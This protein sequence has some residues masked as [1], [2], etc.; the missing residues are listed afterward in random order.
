[1]ASICYFPVVEDKEQLQDI[2]SRA[3]W[4]LTFPPIEKITLFVSEAYLTEVSWEVAP[5]MDPAISTSFDVLRDRLEL[6]VACSEA[7]LEP[8]MSKADIILRWKK[9]VK[10]A[11][12]SDKALKRWLQGKKVFQVD[13]E[14]VR[15]EGSFYIE[16][17][18]Y[19]LPRKGELI[20]ENQKRFREMESALGGFSRAYLLATG[21]SVTQYDKFDFE[22]SLTIACN[23]TILDEQLMK[24]AQPKMLVFADPIFHFGPSEY[25][26]SFRRT[27]RKSS[28]QHD[29]YICIPF[30]YYGLFVHHMP[31]LRHRVIAIPFEKGRDYNFD[32]SSEFKVKTTANILTLLMVPLGTSFASQIC[33]LG[34]DGRPLKEDGYFWSHN[35]AVQFNDKLANIREIHPGFFNIDYNDYYI[36][37]CGTLREQIEAG[38]AIGIEFLSIGFSYIPVLSERL[39]RGARRNRTNLDMAMNKT[40]IVDPDGL[41][42]SGHHI[43]FNDHLAN[44]FEEQGAEVSVLCNKRIEKGILDSRPYYLPT[45]SVHTWEFARLSPEQ[46]RV[47]KFVE[48]VQCGLRDAYSPEHNNI[49]YMYTG[50]VQHVDALAKVTRPYQNVFVHVNLFWNFNFDLSNDRWVKTWKGLFEWLDVSAPHVVVTAPTRQAQ[51]E[52]AEL[53]GVILEVAPHP[54]TLVLEPTG[55][56]VRKVGGRESKTTVLFPG[57]AR[58]EK[59]FPDSIEAVRQLGKFKELRTRLRYNVVQ[60]TPE[61][62]RGGVGQLPD[63]ASLVTGEL[64]DEGLID[65]IKESDVVVLPYSPS[66][67]SK[68]TS[69][70]LIDALMLGVPVVVQEGTWLADLVNRYR[71]G[72]VV[73][74]TDAET[75]VNGILEVRRNLEWYKD[76][77]RE[78]AVLYADRNNW[79]YF[80][81]FIGLAT[82]RAS[83]YAEVLVGPYAREVH[84]HWDETKG[85]AQLFKHTFKGNTM[86]DVGAHHGSALMPF[87]E[88][89]WQILAFEPD[90]KNRAKLLGRLGNH[91]NRENVTVDL[92]AV[93]REARSSVSFYRSEESTGISALSAFR[94][95]HR[96]EQKVDIVRLSEALSANGIDDVDFLKVDTEG[97]DLFVLQGFPWNRCTPQVIECEFEDNKTVPL[98]YKFDDL[99]RYLVDKGYYVYVSEWHPIIRYGTKHDWHRLVRYPCALKSEEAWGNLLAFREPIDEAALKRVVRKEL[100]VKGRHED[101]KAP[102]PRAKIPSG[103]GV[104]DSKGASVAMLVG[105]PR[106]DL[107][108]RYDRAF[109]PLGIRNWRYTCLGR[110]YGIWQ[111]AWPNIPLQPGAEYCGFIKLWASCDANV[112]MSL[113]NHTEPDD[114]GKHKTL[115]LKAGHSKNV[116]LRRQFIQKGH[117]IQLKVNVIDA[118]GKDKLDLNI[119]AF[120]VTEALESA[121]KRL[122]DAQVDLRQ[123]NRQFREGDYLTALATYMLLR[124]RHSLHIYTD[125]ALM[126]AGRLGLNWV[127]SIEDLSLIAR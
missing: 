127:K 27:L 25:A 2:I 29:Y 62:L 103:N 17:G 120:S 69:G 10:P 93:G 96:A 126:A 116:F 81:R 55:A 54:S 34:C 52:F 105:S 26:A 59:G 37:H 70:I 68:R 72:A 11:Y 121:R 78:A 87:L 83:Q 36:E 102:Q 38:E 13:P 85:I 47:E 79:S 60:S 108:V 112:Q 63:N 75:L 44:A 56:Y 46:K 5:G 20:E 94:D 48:E 3:A 77:A 122:P 99:C 67:F 100:T 118:K 110:Y 104:Q 88:Q 125:N 74:N 61:D 114:E 123:A 49:V 86:V 98:G 117:G 97:H 18:L 84:A 89:N 53:F 109:T 107:E 51:R 80:A 14:A 32:L 57:G 7:D 40:I 41:T 8:S 90:A 19:L 111:A 43:P 113:C 95:T 91:R 82:G 65:L 50:S 1:M 71:F 16:A 66:A 15:Q 9:D 12:V 119:A 21:P 73:P 115:Q 45:L 76:R 22:D 23:S 42:R 33:F 30:K 31:D 4:F 58:H 35:P 39:S 124:E 24:T 28:E 101:V 106:S 92:R 64:T 6:V